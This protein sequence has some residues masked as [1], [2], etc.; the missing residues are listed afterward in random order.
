MKVLYDWLKDYTGDALPSL[1]ELENL[2]TFHAFEI[3]GIEEIA[4]NEVIDVKVLPDRG[5]DCLSHRGIAR[6]I[7]TLTGTPLQAD[8]LTTPVS[9]TPE[10]DSLTVSIEDPSRCRRFSAA[11]ITGL[12]VKDSPEWLRARLAALGQRSINNVV[13]ATNYVMLGLGQPLHAYDAE[14]F[15]HEGGVWRFGVRMAREG[16]EVTILGGETYTASPEVQLIVDA[17]SDAPAGIAGI[18][19]GQLAEIDASTTAIILEAANFDPRTTRRAA[20]SLRLPTDASKRF[21]NDLSPELAA[22][23]LTAA[24]ALILDIAGGTLEGYVDAYPTPR[25][26]PRVDVSLAHIEGLLG[27]SLGAEAIEDILRRLGFSYERKGD[28]WAV[29]APFERTDIVIPEDVIAEIGRV[30]GYEHVD[31]IMPPPAPLAEVNARHYYAERIRETLVGL[32][33]SEIITSSFRKKDEIKLR[34]ALASDKGY[35]RSDLRKNVKEALLRNAPYMDLLGVSRIQLFEIG[36]VFCRTDDGADVTEHVSL[37]LGVRTKAGGYAPADD[38]RL[39]EALTALESSLGAPLTTDVHDGVAECDL[40]SVIANL[41]SPA[42]YEPFTP[43]ADVRFRPFS[44]YPFVSR[45]IALW[46]KETVAAADIEAVLREGAGDLLV[47]LSQFDEFK[48]DGRVS[49][50]FR[51][52][53]QSKERTLTDEEVGVIMERISGMLAERSYEVR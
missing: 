4:G 26:N 19:G 32:G 35:L 8:P 48:K 37:A 23:G 42:A 28:A 53:F 25:E 2:L 24:V 27:M 43:P 38:A 50:A 18:K 5:S 13:D 17:K 10:T 20:Q 41:P 46:V 52:V 3:D 51:L 47:R 29:I 40:T 36:T 16:E 1:P 31:A 33:F 12:T 21:E 49:Y 45:D 9:L 39:R 44:E 30:Y 15:P 22:Y 14:K 6:E 34:N 11:R 7:A